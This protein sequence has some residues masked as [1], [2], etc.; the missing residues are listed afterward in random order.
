MKNRAKSFS[1]F[2][3][4]KLSLSEKRLLSKYNDDD[5]KLKSQTN[6]KPKEKCFNLK[7]NF[8][9]KN[10]EKVPDKF[11]IHLRTNNLEKNNSRFESNYYNSI[12]NN[13][14]NK[15]YFNNLYNNENIN[16]NNTYLNNNKS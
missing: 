8:N 12:L 2:K 1:N 9:Y 13:I 7:L 11:K 14:K 6:I 16:K 10:F 3:I 15:E 5:V 4:R